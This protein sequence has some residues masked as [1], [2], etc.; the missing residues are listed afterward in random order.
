MVANPPKKP[1]SSPKMFRNINA[2]K[3]SGNELDTALIVAPLTPEF[4]PWPMIS[5]PRPIHSLA[6]QM[7]QLQRSTPRIRTTIMLQNYFTP[8]ASRPRRTIFHVWK[9]WNWSL[10]ELAPPGWFTSVTAEALIALSKETS[11][12]PRLH[13]KFLATRTKSTTDFVFR[14]LTAPLKT[15][16]PKP[17]SES[18]VR[19]DR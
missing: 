15:W 17:K 7:S 9:C 12:S 13:L 2:T 18:Q 19:W 4:Q 11:P 1:L 14:F 8:I 10:Q 16:Q 3:S 6:S 5:A